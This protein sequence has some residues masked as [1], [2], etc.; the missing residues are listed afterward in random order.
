[1][2][3]LYI[4]LAL[5]SYIRPFIESLTKMELTEGWVNFLTN[6]IVF[7][8]GGSMDSRA[9]AFS[10]VFVALTAVGA[11]ITIP[12]GPV[13]VT[14]QVM[15]VILSGLLL[16]SRLGF[17]SQLLYVLAGMIGF[18]VFSGFSGG[19]AHVFGPTGGYIVAFPLA[20]FVVGD[21]TERSGFG[22]K[23]SLL[24][25][26]LGLGIIYLLGWLW[27]GVYLGNS[28]WAAFKVGV[29]P[30]IGIDVAKAFLAVAIAKRVR[31]HF[32]P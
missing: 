22:F 13:P 16:G 18:P 8:P 26:L 2:E 6:P 7:N 20:A 19:L 15:M 27:L 30:F 12:L 14:L 31:G 3:L 29:L 10:A 17:L 28:F 5:F 32:C 11:W 1:M 25:S 24:G 23:G 9:V 21:I 4:V